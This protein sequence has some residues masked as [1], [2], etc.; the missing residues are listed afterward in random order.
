MINL[1]DEI[2]KVKA[3]GYNEAN[4][5]ARICQDIILCGIANSSF[6]RNVTIKGGV[7]MRNLSKDAR[8]A[9]QD[10]DMDF[11]RYS[12]SEDSIKQFINRIQPRK[13]TYI[14]AYGTYY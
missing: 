3:E 13:W 8:R 2:E 1:L 6:K 7:V 9:T 14:R 12:I 11:L 10:I 5:E 4:A